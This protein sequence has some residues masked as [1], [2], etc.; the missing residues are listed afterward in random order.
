MVKFALQTCW[1]ASSQNVINKQAKIATHLKHYSM[2]PK[3]QSKAMNCAF[4]TIMK[5]HEL[6]P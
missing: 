4:L 2:Q 3:M 6:Q 5:R 1:C